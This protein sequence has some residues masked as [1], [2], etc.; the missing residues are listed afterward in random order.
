M[1]FAAARRYFGIFVHRRTKIQARRRHGKVEFINC[2]DVLTELIND[3]IGTSL[4][5][6]SVYQIMATDCT[7]T[8]ML[9]FNTNSILAEMMY[10]TYAVE[11]K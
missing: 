11:D 6:K 2:D 4:I 1:L 8:I 5:Y 3:K 7:G 10:S 9:F